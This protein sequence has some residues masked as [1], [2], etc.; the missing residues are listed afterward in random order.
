[1]NLALNNLKDLYVVKDKQTNMLN[2][3]ILENE[4]ERQLRDKVHFQTF[5]PL[6]GTK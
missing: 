2:G 6:L 3:D 1:M 4:F 5:I